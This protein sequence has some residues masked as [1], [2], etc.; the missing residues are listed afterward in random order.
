MKLKEKTVFRVLVAL[1]VI[2][3]LLVLYAFILRPAYTGLV[4]DARNDGI[5]IALSSILLQVQQNGYVQ[6]P[7]GNQTLILVPYQASQQDDVVS[8]TG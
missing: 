5:N 4:V 1:V 6:I 3:G 7:V 2:L 8:L